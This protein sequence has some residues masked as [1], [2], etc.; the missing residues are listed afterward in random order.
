[1]GIFDRISRLMRANINDLLDRA[2]NPEKMIDEIIREMEQGVKEGRQQVAAMIAQ[3][4]ELELEMNE[5]SR[6]AQ[7]WGEKA[8]RAV[9]AGKDDLAR[10]ALRRRKDADAN[11][12]VYE[13]Q[14][15]AQERAIATLKSQLATLEVNYQRTLSNRDALLARQ[16]RARAQRQV[17]ER[18]QSFTPMDPTADLERMERMIRQQ[19]AGAAAAIEMQD[20]SLD[21]QFAE[22]DYDI[23]IENQLKALKQ[24][25][26]QQ[27][28]ELPEGGES[29]G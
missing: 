24:G 12:A 29:L 3:Q 6:L 2:E 22:L 20:Q 19:E 11:A 14:L 5:N 4:K 25:V 8:A 18:V 17:A 23:D 7:A 26:S 27:A 21:Q 28:G 9:A 16:K 13:D 10:E 1:M 15:Q